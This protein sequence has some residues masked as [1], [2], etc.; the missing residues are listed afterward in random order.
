[1]LCQSLLC[2]FPQ[3]VSKF[4]VLPAMAEGLKLKD[5][6]MLSLEIMVSTASDTS[7]SC[8]VL[9][10]TFLHLAYVS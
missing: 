9:N 5:S 6:S 4:D 2:Q 1:M 7:V 10:C 3:D 8:I